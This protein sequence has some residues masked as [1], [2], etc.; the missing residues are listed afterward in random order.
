MIG[1]QVDDNL[2]SFQMPKVN[3]K[4]RNIVL[5]KFQKDTL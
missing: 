1:D 3:K 4:M 5:G 2:I